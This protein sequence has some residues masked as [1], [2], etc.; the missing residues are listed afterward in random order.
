MRHGR[1]A[2]AVL[3]LRTTGVADVAVGTVPLKRLGTAAALMTRTEAIVAAARL[4]NREVRPLPS[5][6]W[7]TL[8]ARELRSNQ[9]TMNRTFVRDWFALLVVLFGIR[10]DRFF[11]ALGV[12]RL[13]GFGNCLFPFFVL[14]GRRADLFRV[15]LIVNNALRRGRYDGRQNAGRLGFLSLPRHAR[16]L[17]FV[18][19]VA[20]RTTRLLDVLANHRDDDVVRQPSL[21]R[22]VVIENVTR[23]KL[24]LLHQELPK[25]PR[26]RG[27]EVRK[28]RQS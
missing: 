9:R 28:V 8:N 19:R 4:P 12:L 22:T 10:N 27:K 2:P 3:P 6:R 17:V 26:W 1:R 14:D 15:L 25:D 24:A 16:V 21:A 5:R 18:V 11:S 7:L 23:P 13:I 20:R